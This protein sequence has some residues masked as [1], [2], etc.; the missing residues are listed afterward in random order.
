ME[1]L[2]Q[3]LNDAVARGDWLQVTALA[4]VV[5]GGVVTAGL[6]VAGKPVPILDKVIDGARG[7]LK[8]L[9][10]KPAVEPKPG[11]KQGVEAVVE[12]KPEAPPEEPK[13]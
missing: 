4:V 7:A 5:I 9:P 3:Q 11:E 2:T 10:K 6:K 1:D 8:L 12:V 13:P